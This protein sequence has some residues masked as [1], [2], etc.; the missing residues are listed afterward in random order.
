MNFKMIINIKKLVIICFVICTYTLQAQVKQ[1][2][3][4]S[5]T[6]IQQFEDLINSSGNYQDYKVIKK[7]KLDVIKHSIEDSL[8]ITKDTLRSKDNQI[9][10][11]IKNMTLLKTKYARIEQDLTDAKLDKDSMSILGMRVGKMAYNFWMLFI[12]CILLGLLI[13]FIYKFK[14]SNIIT[15][16]VKKELLK[17]EEDFEEHRRIAIERE[18]K[19]RRQLQDEINKQKKR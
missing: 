11:H 14:Q 1:T 2:V 16:R 6:L 10:T 19:V 4:D 17:I 3:S 8:K 18:Q 9:S 7:K 5:L 13:L 15:Q 12:I